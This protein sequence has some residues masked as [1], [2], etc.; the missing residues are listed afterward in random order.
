MAYA[1]NGCLGSGRVQT[2]I[3][4]APGPLLR[5]TLEHIKNSSGHFRFGHLSDLSD[6]ADDVRSRWWSQPVD[7]TLYLQGEMECGLMGHSCPEAE[8]APVSSQILDDAHHA[9]RQGVGR[10]GEDSRQLGTQR[11]AVASSAIIL[12]IIDIA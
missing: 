10:P 6:Q 8:P 3:E 1:A 2:E 11:S 12:K 7:A 4:I 9:W 5:R